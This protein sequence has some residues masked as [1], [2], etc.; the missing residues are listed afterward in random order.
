M[1][2]NYSGKAL[3]DLKVALV[4]YWLVTWRGGEK[5]I[6]AILDLFPNADIYT[7]FLDDDLKKTHLSN[8]TVYPSVLNKVP[9]FRRHHQ[10]IFPLYPIGIRSLQLKDKYDLIISSESGPAKGIKKPKETPHI[11]YVHTPM[12]YCWGFTHEYLKALPTPV[13]P[14]ANIFLALLREWDKTTIDNVDLYLANSNN[15]KERIRRF[16]NRDAHVI[17]PPID[18]TLFKGD[19][20]KPK[21]SRG[22]YFLSFGAL[23]PYKKIDLLVSL[24]NKRKDKLIIIGDG[25]ERKRLEEKA[26]PNIEFKGYVP[27]GELKDYIINSKALIFP[28][29]EDFGMIP[30]E[31]MAY[32]VPVIA[33][34]K[35]GALETVVEN[36]NPEKSTGLFFHKQS[37]EELAEA[38][39][40]FE[41]LETHFDPIFIREHARQFEESN[42]KKRFYEEVSRF[43]EMSS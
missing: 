41:R 43:M 4:H 3:K 23:V 10:K 42:F 21:G 36:D 33:F 25:S 40:R 7:L 29:E 8:Y 5:V 37:E 26:G 13:R 11:C 20:L 22:Q 1:E 35:G 15:V 30:L 24:F 2:H 17:Y 6:K 12:R 16:Y 14:V 38:I 27:D 28:G 9:L 31:V 34:G 32:G 18:S 19:D 39:N